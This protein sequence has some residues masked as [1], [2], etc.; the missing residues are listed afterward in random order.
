[1]AG[2]KLLRGLL[3]VDEAPIQS[4]IVGTSG[5][6]ESFSR[7]GP[8]DARGRS[9]C[10]FDLK[11]RLFKYPCSYLIDSPQFDALPPR[12]KRY[13]VERLRV[14]LDGKGGK[15][16]AKLSEGD[17]EAISEILAET[18]PDLWRGEMD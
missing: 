11:T 13:V 14:V 10:E 15:E 2:D 12:M 3:F 9:L 18:K 16:Y 4:P 8:R 17:R 5:Y 1:G 6:A 7:R